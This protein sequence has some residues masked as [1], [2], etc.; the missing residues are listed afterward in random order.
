RLR[1]LGVSDRL[2]RQWIAEHGE[3]HVAAKLDYVE[4]QGN[5]RSPV[6]YLTAALRDAVPAVPALP[7]VAE[8]ANP[9]AARLGRLQA[10]V[11]ARSPTQR[12]ADRRMFLRRIEAPA[13][14]AD[15]ERFGWMS[16]LNAAAI[17]AFWE[18]LHPGA[19]DGL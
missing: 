5:V 18:D 8:P 14:R 9:R 17:F 2:A 13:L 3:T 11:S 1:G 7:E 10:L 16:P 19:F 4:G 6:R 12:D 15:F